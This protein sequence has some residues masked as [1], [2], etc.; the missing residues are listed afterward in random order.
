MQHSKQG[1]D[2]LSQLI[3]HDLAPILAAVAVAGLAAVALIGWIAGI[4]FLASFGGGWVPMAPSTAALFFLAAATIFLRARGLPRSR[5]WRAGQ[6]MAI[7]AALAALLLLFLSLQGIYLNAEHPGFSLQHEPGGPPQGHMSPLTAFCFLLGYLSYLASFSGASSRSGWNTMARG[8]AYLLILISV[9]LILAYLY[10]SPLMYESGFVPPAITTSLSFLA[11]GAALSWLAKPHSQTADPQ[12]GDAGRGG[13]ALVLVFLILAAGLVTTGFLHFRQMEKDYRTEIELRLSAIAGLKVDDLA[14]WRKERLGDG[15]VFRGNI[16]FS[17]LV[18]RLIEQPD[19]ADAKN[20]MR[21]WLGQVQ[22]AYDYNLV[23][24]HDA[25][26]RQ[27]LSIPE[28]A[29]SAGDWTPQVTEV[30]QSGQVTLADFSRNEHDSRVYLRLFVPIAD[31]EDGTPLGILVLRIDPHT[32]LYPLISR[33]PAPSMTAETLLVRREGE[34]VVFLNDLRF[35]KDTALSLRF[36]VDQSGLPAARAVRGAEGIVEGSDYRGVPVLACVRAVPGSPWFLVAR[37]DLSEVYAPLRQKLWMLIGF[38]CSLLVAAGAMT[39]AV[40]RRQSALYYRERFTAAE[41]LRLSMERHSVTLKAI[42]DGVLA[43]DARGRVELLNPVAAA[44]IGWH[45]EEACGRPLEEVFRIINEETRDKV[46]NPVAKVLR[47]GQVVGLANHTILIARD[48]TERPI[49]DS[50]APIRDEAGEISGVVLVFRDQSAERAAREALRKSE[51][52]YRQTLD[53]MLE[54]CQIIGPDWKY[55]YVNDAAARQGRK[56]R[57]ELIGRTMMEAFPG[58]ETTPLFAALRPCMEKRAPQRLEN[59]FIHADG[60]TGYFEL[61]IEPVSEGLFILSVD[62]TER[63]RAESNLRHLTAV[64]RALRNVN[65]LITHEK[66]RNR[67]LRRACEIL[68]ETRGYRSAWIGMLAEPEGMRAV[69]ESGIG[70]EFNAL[71]AELERGGWPECCRQALEKNSVVVMHDTAGNCGRCPLAH[72]Y[73]ETAALAGAL[74]HAG[75]NYGVLVAALPADM[76]DNVEEQ[77]LFKELVGDIGFALYSIETDRERERAVAA[78]QESEARYRA[79]FETSADG[80]LIADVE[81]GV[82]KYA[83]PAISRFLDY[84]EAEFAAMG[85]TDIHP[86]DEL[87]KIMAD[88]QAQAR[89]DK[90]LA[91]EIPCIRKDGAVVYADVSAVAVTVDGRTC[92]VGFFR[93]ITPRKRAEA[94]RDRLQAQFIQAQKMESVGR[95]AGGVAHDYNNMLNVIMGYSELALEKVGPEDPLY[96]DLKSILNAAGRSR[97]ITRQLLAFA[98]K[99]TIAPEVLDLNAGVEGLLRILRRLIGEDIDLAWLP[100]NGLWPVLIDPSQLDQILANLCVNARDAIAD[101]GKITIETGRMTFDAAYCAEHAGFVPGDFVVLAVSDDG[102][103]MD[104]A[105]LDKIFEPFFTTKGVGRG[106]G[107]GLATVYGIVKQNNGFINV[108]SEPGEGSTFR[109]YLPRH[110]DD[111]AGVRQQPIEQIPEGRGETLLVV[112]DEISILKLAERILTRQ[113]Y[114]VLTANTPAAAL[115]T[116]KTHAGGIDLLLTDV[117]MPGM[118]GRELAEQMQCLYPKIKCLYMSGYTANVIAHRGVLDKGLH[119]IQK[120]FSNRDLT[121]KVRTVLDESEAGY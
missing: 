70:E 111:I 55:L 118:N 12:A 67:L 4:P 101:V 54:G 73:H 117:V 14:Q 66:D 58:I 109:I 113:K 90:T 104:R 93:D 76:A 22:A 75:S 19:D 53:G 83:N 25:A 107:L 95:L 62:I 6:V 37:M 100:G 79:L 59:E 34:R 114:R 74:R 116:A 36:P 85:V 49:A 69:A 39:A 30:L 3:M 110:G 57:G 29:E 87:P 26:G 91:E 102:C 51:A 13:Y 5:S 17:G 78:L 16:N 46:E 50:G 68:T 7:L 41:A 84:S 96:D 43:T 120:P 45:Q 35:K 121:S 60:S 42:G 48:G 71:C 65:Q 88:F 81:T 8:T 32:Y 9:V 63:R 56:S 40:W 44:L 105:T 61:N 11:L 21:T 20:R 64:L 97:D 119:F 28:A 24:L 47:E 77:S 27:L 80:I 2:R 33:W 10:G 106:T 15:A 1:P 89:G 23:S 92:N 31:Q 38:V 99:E 72:T 82:F 115:Q 52:R 103:G 94:E 18:R 108:Y 98:R 86:E 112:E